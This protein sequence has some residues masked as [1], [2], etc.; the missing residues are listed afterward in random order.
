MLPFGYPCLS[1]NL[2]KPIQS[3]NG[4]NYVFKR[5]ERYI[6][7]SRTL[8]YP[9][10]K[11]MTLLPLPAERVGSYCRLPDKE[12]AGRNCE[13]TPLEEKANLKF[14]DETLEQDFVVNFAGDPVSFTPDGK[15]SVL[16]AIGTLTHSKCA[17]F[18][19]DDVKKKY[20]EIVSHCG[21][22]S[23]QKGHFLSVVDCEGW[24]MLW[25]VLV[26]YLGES[27]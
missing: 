6:F 8:P 25:T 20:P 16:D 2:A 4:V 26:D 23:F 22:Y 17:G 7:L 14:G 1:F 24:N 10:N 27:D 18:L 13:G 9:Q 21:S 19:W 12:G 5:Y 11:E 15:V 3:A